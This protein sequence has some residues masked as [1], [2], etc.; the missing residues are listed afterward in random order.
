MV[1]EVEPLKDLQD[2]ATRQRT[3][4]RILSEYPEIKIGDSHKT[5]RLRVNPIGPADIMEYDSP[6]DKFLGKNRFDS[7]AFP[8]LYT[9]PDIEGCIHECRVTIEDDLYLAVLKPTRELRLLNLTE[10]LD[11]D[12]TEFESL[13]MAVH[14]LFFASE[15]SYEISREIALSASKAGYD[16]LI[17]PSYFSQSRSGAT[18]LDTVFGISIRK[19][20]PLQQQ[21][22]SQIAENVCFFGRP[23]KEKLLT[24]DC[25]NRLMLKRAM[26][27]YHFG[28]II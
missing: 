27:E 19:L 22:R 7:K 3:I 23:I 20:K 6:P 15:H 21:A 24:V 9:S 4:D 17:Y 11:E 1:G 10:L 28:P 12:G 18:P 8:V 5:F 16:G 14:M 25:I 2:V 13:D 26:Y